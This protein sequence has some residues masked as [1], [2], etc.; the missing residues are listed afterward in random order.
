M[1]IDA[2]IF[3]RTQRQY[4]N[5][6]LVAMTWRFK[7]AIN[8]RT[9]YVSLAVSK[10]DTLIVEACVCDRYYGDGYERGHW[11]RLFAIIKW[12]SLNFTDGV[13]HYGSDLNDDIQPIDDASLDM[14]WRHWAA[15]GNTPY[16]GQLRAPVVCCGGEIFEN[17]T[18]GLGRIGYCPA[19]PRR[20]HSR[21]G[22]WTEIVQV[23]EPHG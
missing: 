15:H 12:M 2:V 6:E 5:D 21:G 23:K 1:G 16:F 20:Y 9:E 13:V 14:L 8:D 11:P 10:S 18:D 22:V 3:V 4:S 17:G 19:C 7:E